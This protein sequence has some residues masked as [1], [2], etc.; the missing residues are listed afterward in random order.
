MKVGK[1][2]TIWHPDKSVLLNCVIGDFCTIHAPVW[3]GNNVIIG[4]YCK[5][6]AFSFIPEGVQLSDHVFI[7]P[8]VCFTNDKHPPSK[9]WSTTHVGPFASIGANATILPG[10]SIGAHAMVGAG[11]V[12]TRDVGIS[13]V[14]YGN[15]A[16][17]QR[18]RAVA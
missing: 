11:A 9:N 16:R 7:G 15:P 10:V 5:I 17:K 18:Y 13:E 2:T 14:V 4:N 6:Q 1:N 8:H 12:V 3:I